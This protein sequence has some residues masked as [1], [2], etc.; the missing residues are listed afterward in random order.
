M[1]VLGR[2]TLRLKPS[3]IAPNASRSKSVVLDN[4]RIRFRLVGTFHADNETLNLAGTAVEV[5]L[6]LAHDH[7][8]AVKHFFRILLLAQASIGLTQLIQRF[9]IKCLTAIG[10]S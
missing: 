6:L 1:S 4:I 10:W 3:A 9:R 7:P 5:C 2:F 8:M